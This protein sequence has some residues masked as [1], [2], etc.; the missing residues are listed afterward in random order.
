MPSKQENRPDEKAPARVLSG[1]SH[2]ERNFE[3]R[4][5]TF[6][7]QIAPE[8][9]WSL[10]HVVRDEVFAK[11]ATHWLAKASGRSGRIRE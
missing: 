10:L 8:L 7:I 6:G 2:H 9:L 11:A 4:E 3:K 5:G 1:K